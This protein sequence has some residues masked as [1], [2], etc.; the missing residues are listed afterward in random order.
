MAG[1]SPNRG[2]T[3]AGAVFLSYASQDGEAARRICE[4]LQAAGIE[5]WFDQSELRGGDIWDRKI[6]QQIRDCTLFLPIVSQNTQQRLE[7]YFRLE[8]RLAVER[9]HLMA[10]ERPFL[11]PVVVDVTREQEAVVPEAFKVV[12]WTR[13]P[14]GDTPPAFVEHVR[15]L[16]SPEP[17]RGTASIRPEASAASGS[18]AANGKSVRAS[19]RLRPAVLVM[20]AMA[21]LVALLAYLG[22]DNMRIVEHNPGSRPPASTPE[23]APPA[24][25]TSAAFAPPPHSI[26]VLPFVNMSGDREQDYF[27]DGLSEELLNSLARINELQVAARTSSFYFKGERADLATI[28]RKLNVAS[29]LEGSVRRSG[30]TLRVAAQLNNAVTGYQLWSQTYDRDLGDVLKLQTEIANA[31]AD[32]LKVTLLGDVAAKIEVGGTR[33]PAAFDAHL[34]A[35]SAYRRFG[36]VNLAAGGLNKEG[37]QTAID[38]YTEAIRADSE[39][40]LAYAGRSLAFAD[41]A[42]ALVSGPD[43]GQYLSQAQTDARKAIALAPELADGHLALANFSVGSLDLAGALQEYQRALA[44]A[45]GDARVLNEFG[46]FAVLI[47]RTEA[48]LAAAHR[49]LVLDPLNSMNHFGLGT[50][51]TFA[52]RYGDAIRAFSDAKALGLDDVS[53]NMWLGIAYY[54]SGDFENARATCVRAGEVNGP[55]CL[56]M[57]YEKLGRHGEAEAMLAKI[58][59]LAGDQFAEGYADVYAQWGD[60][61]H[62][63]DWLETAM[64]NRDPYLAYTKVNPF[65]DPLRNEPRYQ[66]IERA[67]KF[68][69]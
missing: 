21:A 28:A 11:V 20:V 33:D 4:A 51:L 2:G 36:P 37:L 5:V 34:R 3:P 31:V 23:T 44:L 54:L 26:A 41:F 62:A 69:D 15:R 40:A 61:A 9:S 35:S 52:R 18:A 30:H 57:V 38:A 7:G 46:A 8:W 66:A 16:L 58:R 63:L 64:R 42:R 47:G 56:S 1:G 45:P 53:I 10:I 60:T 12:Q 65:F 17:F 49:L 68:P 25:T 6:R 22:I 43:V 39:Y 19:S 13:V 48:G 59:A 27:S 32:A 24:H 50:S 14:A 55:W 67:L 29:V